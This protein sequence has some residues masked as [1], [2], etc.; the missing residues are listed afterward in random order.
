MKIETIRGLSP[1]GEFVLNT[2]N[3]TFTKNGKELDKWEVFELGY[4]LEKIITGQTPIKVK[5]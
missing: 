1:F 5:L 2:R 4:K 3:M